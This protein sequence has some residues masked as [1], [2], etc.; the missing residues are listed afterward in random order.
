D[1]AGGGAKGNAARVGPRDIVVTRYRYQSSQIRARVRRQERIETAAHRVEGPSSV[2][3][4]G[5][6]VP[7]GFAALIFGVIWLPGFLGRSHIVARDRT[8]IS[9]NDLRE[10]EVVVA[11]CWEGSKDS[12]AD[13]RATR[14]GHPDGTGRHPVGCSCDNLRDG[15]DAEGSRIQ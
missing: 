5:P 10:A 8:G 6:A 4:C 12:G 7:N 9:R 13:G 15:G 1:R 2:G 3:G 11:G 14:C